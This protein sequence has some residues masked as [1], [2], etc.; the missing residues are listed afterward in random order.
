M[1]NRRGVRILIF[2]LFLSLFLG[3]GFVS[4]VLVDRFFVTPT[5]ASANSITPT[6]EL[7]LIDQAYQII[8]GTMLIA[9]SV[10]QTNW[11]CCHQRDGRCT[12]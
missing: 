4:G 7:T 9:D 6:T 1:I 5:L 8:Q 3:A 2:F 11:V 12:R 10:D